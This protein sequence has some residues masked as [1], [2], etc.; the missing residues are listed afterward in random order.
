MSER[1]IISPH[2]QGTD[3]WRQDRLGRVTGSN[4][5][6]I[7]AKGRGSNESLQRI[8][9]RRTLL[10]E[11]LT[12]LDDDWGSSASTEWGVEQEPHSR[13]AYELRTGLDIQQIGF[14]YLPDLMAGCSVD[15]LINEDGRIGVWESKSPKSKTHLEY[16]LA[17]EVPDDYLRQVIH[18]VWITGAEFADFQSYDPRM[19][20]D[21][22]LFIVRVWRKDLD[23]EGHERGVLQFLAELDA[24]EKKMRERIT[25]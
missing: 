6:A 16:L 24:E 14:I 11:R 22:R 21:L 5:A 17:G 25:N 18:N 7:F 19:P 1:Y 12:G 20:E 23:I 10:A 8:T 4:C 2:A 3:G 15:G 13:M 9:L